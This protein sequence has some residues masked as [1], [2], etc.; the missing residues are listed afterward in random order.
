MGGQEAKLSW[1]S[2]LTTAIVVQGWGAQRSEPRQEAGVGGCVRPA[3][4]SA[5]DCYIC[6]PVIQQA[7]LTTS[8]FQILA[9][10][11]GHYRGSQAVGDRH[12][13]S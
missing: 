2:V 9:R 12:T 5:G 3:P 10:C 13:Q 7:F 11:T 8:L 4:E 6:A 1:G